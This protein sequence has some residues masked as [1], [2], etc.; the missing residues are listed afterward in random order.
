MFLLSQ[1]KNNVW[2]L[3]LRRLIG[4]S[5]QTA[6]R[7]KHKLMQVMYE[8]ESLHAASLVSK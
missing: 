5:Y 8:R 3:E 6:W 7:M 2:T 1:K 4:V